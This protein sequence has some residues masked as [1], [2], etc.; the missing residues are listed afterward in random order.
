MT[1]RTIL[2]VAPYFPPHTGGLERYVYEI[3][4]EL[5][6]AGN[7]VVVVTTGE[8]KDTKETEEGMTIYR[9]APDMII[10]NTPI[11][12]SWFSKVRRILREE[13]PD[14]VNVHTPVP[15]LGDIVALCVP[16][17]KL[18]VT[19]H[20]GTMIKGKL[21]ADILIFL[22]ERLALPLLLSRARHI[23]TASDNTRL[24]FLAR[25]ASKSSTIPPAVDHD[26]FAP[27]G[28][29]SPQKLLFVAA[30]LSRATAYKGLRTLLEAL[31]LVRTR[32]FTLEV[33]GDGDMKET[34]EKLAREKGL[35]ERV[36]F[37]GRLRGD[38]LKHA[39]QSASIF[40]LPSEKDSYPISLLEASAAGCA[41]IATRVGD[42]PSIVEDGH[43]GFLITPR[44]ALELRERLE[45]L[46]IDPVLT[47]CFG[48]NARKKIVRE[49]R[50]HERAAKY[51][52]IF[53][54]VVG[55]R[56]PIA[57]VC[58]YYPPHIGG[59]E[60]FVETAA[61]LLAAR[62][63]PTSVLTSNDQFS[64]TQEAGDITVTRLGSVEFAHTPFAPALLFHLLNLPRRTIVHLHFAQ[65]YW[66]EMVRIAC[67]LKR[68]PY[69]IHFHLDVAPSGSL[70]SLFVLYKRLTWRSH[71]RGAERVVVCSKEQIPVVCAY[72]VDQ[73]KIVVIPNAIDERFFSDAPYQPSHEQFRLLYVGRLT[74]QKRVD[75]LLEALAHVS[76][77]A[78]LT[79]VG[80]GE[81]RTKLERR[82]KELGLTN[83]SFEGFKSA[84]EIREYHRSHDAL[85]ISSDKEGG[86]PI[87]VLEGMAAGLP[88]IGTSVIGIRDLLEGVGELVESPYPEGFTRTIEELWQSP[89]LA[90]LSAKSTQKAREHTWER[91]VAALEALYRDISL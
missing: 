17:R 72:G 84:D 42:I 6:K 16:K 54:R 60:R 75:R 90:E 73:S 89:R 33:I 69:V 87:V 13:R 86:T 61:H 56:P 43:T 71:L 22:Y 58:A 37:R 38:A 12:F 25:Y 27:G 66:P 39:F 26:Y 50:W 47:K 35:A 8:G 48:D 64:T 45:T 80:D 29:R 76:I 67:T 36:H 51:G 49:Y 85:L 46:L 1:P 88:I 7:R 24:G 30:D 55:P 15:G 9:L 21:P 41:I 31:A 23:I 83:V 57:H 62:G 82:A 52:E 11:A 4:R 65:A 53:E 79:I 14:I 10:S 81:D 40:V 68:M 77:P 59:I 18:V 44:S 20:T 34:Y 91:T 63:V 19:Y 5:H 74:V 32:A 3:G 70:G 2:L 28:D 78:R